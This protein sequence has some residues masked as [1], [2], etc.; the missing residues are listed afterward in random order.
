MN[1]IGTKLKDLDSF[2]RPVTL[3]FRGNDRYKTVRGGLITL[4]SYLC[5]LLLSMS[6]IERWYTRL[7]PVISTY[8]V[9]NQNYLGRKYL[10]QTN[11][12]IIL[13]QYDLSA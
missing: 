13:L 11:Q 5:A 6:I 4:L 1:Y 7:D 9:H 8:E 12:M 2:G 10:D 3:N